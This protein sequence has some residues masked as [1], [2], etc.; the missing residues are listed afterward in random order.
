MHAGWPPS[1]PGPPRS[2][3][4]KLLW[5]PRFW[6]PLAGHQLTGPFIS[7]RGGG[8][9]ARLD[10]QQRQPARQPGQRAQAVCEGLGVHQH[11]AV[12]RVWVRQRKVQG[13]RA[14]QRHARDGHWPPDLRQR[15]GPRLGASL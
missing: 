5:T 3:Q 13:H 4:A 12:R 9:R 15:L 2:L 10:Q 7:Q 6:L 14:S 8:Q 1:S 11:Q